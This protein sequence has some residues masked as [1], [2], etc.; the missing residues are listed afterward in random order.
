M[1]T[2]IRRTRSG[3]CPRAITGRCRERRARD[4]DLHTR[5]E[6]RTGRGEKP[7][8]RYASRSHHQPCGPAQG[9]SRLFE[10]YFIMAGGLIFYGPN[11]AE[12]YRARPMTDAVEKVL[13]HL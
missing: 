8:R 3:C 9:A 2:P 1:S 12:N 13:L 6:Q 11:P 7:E 4:R 10:R 5:S